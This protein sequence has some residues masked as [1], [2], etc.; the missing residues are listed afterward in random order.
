MLK[1]MATKGPQTGGMQ[2]VM[3]EYVSL[4]GRRQSFSPLVRSLEIR[5][6]VIPADA[7]IQEDSPLDPAFA[8]VTASM[9]SF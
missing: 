8:G 6:C 7:G 4:A 2:K 5:F 1:K 9:T 3:A